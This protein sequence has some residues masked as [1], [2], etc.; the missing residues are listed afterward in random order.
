MY[1]QIYIFVLIPSIPFKSNIKLQNKHLTACPRNSCLW[2]CQT[3]IAW[4]KCNCCSYLIHWIRRSCYDFQWVFCNLCI[5]FPLK[6]NTRCIFID[7]PEYSQILKTVCCKVNYHFLL[8]DQQVMRN[9]Q[10]YHWVFITGAKHFHFQTGKSIQRFNLHLDRSYETSPKMTTSK[11]IFGSDF[12]CGRLPFFIYLEL[13][14]WSE[15]CPF[16]YSFL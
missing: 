5:P 12:H 6:V 9:V 14:D 8:I 4:R 16:L 1:K 2:V 10:I 13:G 15:K 7:Y 11:F 3:R